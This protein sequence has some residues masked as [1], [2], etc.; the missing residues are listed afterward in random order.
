MLIDRFADRC[1]HPWIAAEDVSAESVPDDA[2]NLAYE[3]V[4]REDDG[5]CEIMVWGMI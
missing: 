3:A 2:G 5:K 1:D 4:R